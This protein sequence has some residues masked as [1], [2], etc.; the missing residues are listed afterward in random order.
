MVGK[1]F[2]VSQLN[3]SKKLTKRQPLTNVQN[4]EIPKYLYYTDFKENYLIDFE[5]VQSSRGTL[6]RYSNQQ[7]K[8]YKEFK[9]FISSPNEEVFNDLFRILCKDTA[10][11]NYELDGSE[12]DKSAIMILHLNTF[13]KILELD[14]IIDFLENETDREKINLFRFQN[15][16]NQTQNKENAPKTI[17]NTHEYTDEKTQNKYSVPQKIKILDMLNI[18]GWLMDKHNFT[19]FQIEELLSDLFDRTDKTI[20]NSFSDSKHENTAQQYLE[21][22]KKVKAKR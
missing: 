17:D 2:Y 12:F 22:L 8:I 9:E 18:K 14:K 16:T 11:E 3:V 7:L 15:N 10:L 21:E 1:Y 4:M 20:R 13:S 6:L 5:N 19:T